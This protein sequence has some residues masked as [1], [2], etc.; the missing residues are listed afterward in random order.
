MNKKKR[1]D[2]WREKRHDEWVE[3]DFELLSCLGV[4]LEESLGL[5]ALVSRLCSRNSELRNCVCQ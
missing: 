5:I 1:M 4:H 3:A 2:G